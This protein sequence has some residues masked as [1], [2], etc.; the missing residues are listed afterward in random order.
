MYPAL[1]NLLS[2]QSSLQALPAN[3]YTKMSSHLFLLMRTA[4]LKSKVN[5]RL[6]LCKR[7]AHKNSVFCNFC[8]IAEPL[9]GQGSTH[10]SQRHLPPNHSGS[11][12]HGCR[13][14]LSSCSRA[15]VKQRGPRRK[16]KC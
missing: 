6:S 3:F 16:V 1:K 14:D 4:V 2:L 11:E 15:D 9:V 8:Y 13:L 7:V 12:S 10:Q 5:V